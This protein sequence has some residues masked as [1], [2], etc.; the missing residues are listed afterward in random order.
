MVQYFKNKVT[1]EELNKLFKNNTNKDI[2][3]S[4]YPFFGS[5]DNTAFYIDFINDNILNNSVKLKEQAIE[6]SI[7][8]GIFKPSYINAIK[9][10]VYSRRGAWIKLTCLDWL[11]NFF[12][13]IPEDVYLEMNNYLAQSNNE[14]LKIQSLININL[15][16]NHESIFNELIDFC[17]KCKDS[18]VFYRLVRALS[19]LDA[20]KRITTQE[21]SKTHD[22]INRTPYLSSSQ[23]WELINMIDSVTK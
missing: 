12:N 20:R 10:I 11:F 4:E 3:I 23:R 21:I 22:V 7:A 6:L 14:L 8:V 15:A 16:D 17:Q 2:F 19:I 13:R 18:A 1:K 9:E 5:D